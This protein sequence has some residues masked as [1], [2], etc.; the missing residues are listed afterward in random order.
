ML[1]FKKGRMLHGLANVM[2]TLSRA[3]VNVVKMVE[4][5]YCQ[6][7]LETSGLIFFAFNTNNS[8][9]SAITLESILSYFSPTKLFETNVKLAL[10]F[11]RIQNISGNR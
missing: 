6:N 5:I 3:Y 9:F 11:P 7:D 2:K 10:P 1:I 8:K 4:D